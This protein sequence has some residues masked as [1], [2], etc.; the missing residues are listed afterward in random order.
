MPT[1]QF[2][3]VGA[4][5]IAATVIFMAG[6]LLLRPGSP[7]TFKLVDDIGQIVGPTIMLLWC[8]AAFAQPSRTSALTPIAR[9]RLITAGLLLAGVFC[10]T[11]GQVIWAYLIHVAQE[12]H[13]FPGPADIPWVLTYVFQIAGFLS[14]S[15]RPLP[16]RTRVR[17]LL[18]GLIILTVLMTFTWYFQVGPMVLN[19]HASLLATLVGACYPLGD[20]LVLFCLLVI[21]TT[22]SLAHREYTGLL[23]V[24][25][26]FVVFA[27]TVFSY[28]NVHGTYVNGITDIGWPCGYMI[29][30]YVARQLIVKARQGIEGDSGHDDYPR[31]E[32]LT[33]RSL[34]PYACIP[35]LGVLTY[36]TWDV[37]GDAGLA[38][39]VFI[40]S[41]LLVGCLLVRQLI[42]LFD[43]QKLYDVIVKAND[44]LLDL[45]RESQKRA[46]EVEQANRELREAQLDLMKNNI[47]LAHVND[48]LEELAT[49]D[50]MTGLANH[51]TFQD[52]LRDEIAVAT[53]GETPLAV[54]L[55]DVD[56]FKDYNDSF[57]HPAG[58]DVLRTIANLISGAA[59]KTDT[60][61]RYGGEEFV[62]LLPGVSAEETQMVA[63]RVRV[64]IEAHEFAH[65]AVTI[66]GGIAYH[67]GG[68]VDADRMITTA[69][70]ALYRA[71]RKGRNCVVFERM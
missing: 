70:D 3:R 71:K 14:L 7:G 55:L 38:Y 53:L 65:R 17:V 29:V 19:S 27:D 63:E 45:T 40:G 52:R 36:Y 10:N 66:S 43:N 47:A 6:W 28:G 9:H 61:A 41:E 13:P 51:R 23:S 59:R 26:I 33:W 68:A 67:Q 18:D 48:Q 46:A 64:T 37:R 25:L 1:R 56:R 57:G 15:A 44:E 2:D 34:L 31:P 62:M 32:M 42:A 24:G 35:P 20:L 8:A 22:S 16:A 4:A 12:K 11:L 49:R 21:A 60:V 50:G 39:G 54:L 30:A 58:D 5:L 69:D